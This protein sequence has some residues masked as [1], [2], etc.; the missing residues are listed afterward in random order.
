LP[1]RYA[2]TQLLIVL[3]DTF[4]RRPTSFADSIPSITSFTA[5]SLNSL[6]YFP[7]RQSFHHNTSVSY[8]NR[9]VGVH[10]SAYL[11]RYVLA[12]QHSG[13]GGGAFPAVIG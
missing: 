10:F 12:D 3:S 9:S 1:C 11:R 5:S 7:P 8:F 2:R 6:L 4:S 13:T